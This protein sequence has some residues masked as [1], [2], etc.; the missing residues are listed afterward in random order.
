MIIYDCHGGANQQWNLNSDGTVANLL[1][2][3]CLDVTGAGTTNGTPVELWNCNG[4][5]NQKSARQ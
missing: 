5:S 2:S 1:S 3:L 4:G